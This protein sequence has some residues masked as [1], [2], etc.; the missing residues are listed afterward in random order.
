MNTEDSIDDPDSVNVKSK[1]SS[2][3]RF[4]YAAIGIP[5]GMLVLSWFV[6]FMRPR[7]DSSVIPLLGLVGGMI[8]AF[9]AIVLSAI[10]LKQQ[11]SVNAKTGLILGLIALPVCVA[12]ALWLAMMGIAAHPV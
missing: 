3:L 11:R 1:S 4:A 5:F 8:P 7:W 2:G 12:I 9:L 10:A 6:P